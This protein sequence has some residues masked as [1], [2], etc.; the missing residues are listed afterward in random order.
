MATSQAISAPKKRKAYPKAPRLSRKSCWRYRRSRIGRLPRRLTGAKRLRLNTVGSE[1]SAGIRKVA[2]K[3][4]KNLDGNIIEGKPRERNLDPLDAELI[5]N[6]FV[7]NTLIVYI[8][9]IVFIHRTGLL[10]T[11]KVDNNE[12]QQA[13][14]FKE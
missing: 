6:Y 1:V 2:Y 10:K 5:G 9:L 11:N 8:R 4:T 14:I 7:L 12:E 13:R 3:A